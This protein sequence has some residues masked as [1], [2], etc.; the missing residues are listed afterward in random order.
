VDYSVNTVQDQVDILVVDDTMA[1]LQILTTMLKEKGYKV[2]PVLDGKTALQAVQMKIPDLICLDINMPGMNGYEVCEA[3]KKNPAFK[4]IPVI[5]ISA[6]SEPLDKVKA[7]SLGGVDYITKP[8]QLEEVQARIDTHLRLHRLLEEEILDSQMATILALAELAEFRDD[9]F[10][11][12]LKRIQHFSGLLVTRFVEKGFGQT[13]IPRNFVRNIFYASTLHDIGKVGIPDSILLKPGKLTP[14]EFE[15]MKSH[16]FIGSDL[17][18]KVRKQYPKNSF[19]NV[20]IEI[21]RSHHEKWDGSG[22]PDRLSGS[23]IPVSARILA[24]ADVYDA[25]RSKRPYKEPF[26]HEVTYNRII[27]DSGTHFDP[28]IVKIFMEIHQ[29]FEDTYN[30]LI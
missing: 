18:E 2:R 7:F 11:Q 17:L 4:D 30:R 14:E 6:L 27:Q 13:I 8:F 10:G 1:N 28:D 9:D 26:S 20:G 19:I 16:T 25:M 22:Y 21:S 23:N 15:T 12:H 29:D 5:F 3:L 24:L